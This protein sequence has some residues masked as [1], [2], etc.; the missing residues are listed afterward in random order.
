MVVMI[1]LMKLM[2]LQMM[3]SVLADQNKVLELRNNIQSR[4]R[5]L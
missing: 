3:I 5:A 1:I 2:P 4:A